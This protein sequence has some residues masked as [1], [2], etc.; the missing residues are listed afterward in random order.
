[1]PKLATLDTQRSMRERVSLK[2]KAVESIRY[3]NSYI[4]ALLEEYNQWAYTEQLAPQFKGKWRQEV[5]AVDPLHP[6]DLEIGTGN[7]LFFANRALSYPERCLIGIERKFKPLIQAIRRA[8]RGG[9]LNARMV[10]YDADLPWDLFAPEELNN[11][12][13]HF[14]DPWVKP[15]WHKNRLIQHAYMQELYNLQ[16]S[17]SF[18]EFKTDHAP[19]FDHALDVFKNGPYKI[20]GYTYDLHKSEFASSNFVT[21]FESLFLRKG[22]PINYALLC[23]E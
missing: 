20:Q 4:V 9:A 7:G 23:K 6:L 8:R 2:L 15:R 3:P 5:F 14:P 11:I 13:I 10:R 16:R 21:Q 19:Y 1:M 22:Q 12:Y 17:G 18:M